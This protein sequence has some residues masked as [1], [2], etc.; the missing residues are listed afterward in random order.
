M[1]QAKDEGSS[2]RKGKEVAVDDPL[3]KTVGEETP[4]SE[5]DHSEEEE[6]G[7]DPNSECAP[8]IDPWYETHIHFLVVP[9]DYSP[10]L[11][12]HVWL[13]ICRRDIEVS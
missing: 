1:L 6:Q 8:L 2:R 3:A 7:C 12:G 11:S 4:F 13:S 5:S 10:P 9:S